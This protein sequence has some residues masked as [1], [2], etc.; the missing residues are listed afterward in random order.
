MLWILRSQDRVLFKAK[1]FDG[2]ER[3]D[4]GVLNLLPDARAVPRA[5]L[6]EMLRAALLEFVDA[7]GQPSRIEVAGDDVRGGPA[8]FYEFR[9]EIEGARLF[10]KTE[11]KPGPMGPGLLVMSVKRQY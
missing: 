1:A 6:R 7:G 8:T 9:L 5:A 10:I 4:E 3:S 2:G 11:L